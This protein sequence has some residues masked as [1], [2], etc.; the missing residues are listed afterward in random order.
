MKGRT[1]TLARYVGCRNV[2]FVAQTAT[3]YVVS[4]TCHV[5]VMSATWAKFRVSKG[6]FL[7]YISTSP[8]ELSNN[9]QMIWSRGK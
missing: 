9:K 7:F 5:A 6:V 3:C 2:N 8:S 1:T 4:G